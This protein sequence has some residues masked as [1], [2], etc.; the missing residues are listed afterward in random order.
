[1]A[2]KLVEAGDGFLTTWAL[3]VAATLG[4][5]DLIAAG[6]SNADELARATSSDEDALYRTLPYLETI[7]VVREGPPRSFEP[8]EQGEY[9]RSDVPGSVRAWLTVNGLVAR[10]FFD[11]PLASIK[12][13]G[14]AFEGV[15]GTDFFG[16]ARAN[17]G[18]GRTFDESMTQATGETAKAV[19][20]AY[21]FEGVTRIV[22]V[23]VGRG[24]LLATF[25]TEHS[26]ATGVLFDQPHVVADAWE[27]LSAAGVAERCEVVTGDFFESVP[28]GGD[29]YVLSWIV[30]D[31]GDQRARSIL[32]NCRR[33]MRDDARLLLVEAV[34]PASGTSGYDFAT[35]LDLVML[36]ALGG[37]ERTEAEYAR[38]LV[39]AGFTLTKI[40][41]TASPMSVLEAIPA[42]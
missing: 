41:P 10:A 30:H 36:V 42:V 31:W 3:Y 1:M 22:D 13:G 25:L 12:T 29:V 24:I 2:A 34:L 17:P 38:L 9:L 35:S 23:G 7:G 28:E 15:F 21:G 37:R 19:L 39:N 27:T 8:T 14:P 33:A 32:T 18:W 4:V 26:E 40:V 5:V 11:D 6:Q 16:F 20:A